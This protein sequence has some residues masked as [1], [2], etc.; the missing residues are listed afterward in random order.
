MKLPRV[1]AL[2]VVVLV[3][4]SCAGPAAVPAPTKAPAA[5]PEEAPAPAAPKTETPTAP[6]KPAEPKKRLM[7]GSTASVSSHYA[8]AVAATKVLN[9]DIPE[10]NVTVVETGGGAD[11]LKRMRKG[12]LD[13][14]LN[15]LDILYQAYKG[16][17]KDWEQEPMGYQRLLWVYTLDAV[18]FV[19][20]ED[21]GIKTLR[22]LEGK[23]F[24]PSGRGTA[25]EALVKNVMEAVGIRPKWYIGGIE[26]AVA[27]VKDRRIVGFVKVTGVKSPDAAI[28][29]LM[30]ATPIRI[31][32]WPQD[33]LTKAQEQ[34]PY[35]L[36]G[37]IAAGVFKA[38]WNQKPIRTWGMAV[39][40]S[41]PNKLPADLA[42][43]MARA[44]DQDRVEQG[45]AYKPSAGVDFGKLTVEVGNIP[46]HA[47]AYRYYKERGLSV[48]DALIPSE[49]K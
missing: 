16:L 6:A 36:V 20:R 19:V 47:G 49:A 13:F 9:R 38:E 30:T 32:E 1:L 10:I 23:E 43:K 5:A 41:A 18:A 39:G 11:N 15:G 27:A 46:L 14:S 21:S 2:G 29:D 40:Y 44:I 34:Y 25:S 45:A 4:V 26:D 7:M 17:G 42:Y 3:A 24:N 28:L 12:E 48:P 37:E 35:Y 33:L 31:L 22:E 8:Y